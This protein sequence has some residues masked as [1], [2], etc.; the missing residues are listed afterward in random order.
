MR[1]SNVLGILMGLVVVWILGLWLLSPWLE[2]TTWSLWEAIKIVG[3]G[4]LVAGISLTIAT[5]NERASAATFILLLVPVPLFGFILAAGTVR[6]LLLEEHQHKQAA[7]A[8]TM[9]TRQLQEHPAPAKVPESTVLP[10]AAARSPTAKPAGAQGV[11]AA[12]NYQ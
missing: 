8:K 12:P 1:L 2:P 3:A 4:G 11:V 5:L 10:L 7:I 9:A 6:E